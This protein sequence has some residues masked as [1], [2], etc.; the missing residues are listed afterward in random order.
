[1]GIKEQIP[2]HA[3]GHANATTHYLFSKHGD[4]SIIVTLS[5][6]KDRDPIQVAG[7]LTHEAVHIWQTI[8]EQIN[9]KYPSRE[10]EA[11]AIQQITQ[12]LLWAYRELTR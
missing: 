12:Q 8:K 6:Y 1:M 7:L 10:F 2:F 3:T 9:E 11:Y 5:D 4:A